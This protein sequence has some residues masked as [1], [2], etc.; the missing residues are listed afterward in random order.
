MGIVKDFFGFG[1]GFVWIEVFV[2]G[3]WGGAGIGEFL[4]MS[5]YFL[6]NS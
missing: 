1:W 5:Y 4:M 6:G 2:W 3:D